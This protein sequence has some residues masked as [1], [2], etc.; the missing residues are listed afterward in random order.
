MEILSLEKLKLPVY[1]LQVN[2]ELLDNE[3]E[4]FGVNFISLVEDPATGIHWTALQNQKPEPEEIKYSIQ[5]KDKRL[6]VSILLE[7]EQIIYRNASKRIPVQHAVVMDAPTIELTANYFNKKGL[8]KNINQSHVKGSLVNSW[9]A[10][11]WLVDDPEM[12][13]TKLYL[14]DK[15]VKAGSWAGITYI[16]DEQYWQEFIKT[17]KLKG[18]SI[19][20]AFNSFLDS[21]IEMQ[22]Q[23]EDTD[24]ARLQE[25]ISILQAYN[26]TT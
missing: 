12:D 15:I 16:K 5:N 8:H 4:K 18:F 17:G 14:K 21:L 10:Q 25:I 9:L 13:K 23:N 7:P 20:G 26:V 1:R 2:E 24:E 22:Y 3:K 11:N 6:L 19:E